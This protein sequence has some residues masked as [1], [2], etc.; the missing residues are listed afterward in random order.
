MNIDFELDD[1][2]K[3]KESQWMARLHHQYIIL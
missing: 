1:K 3:M 2:Q